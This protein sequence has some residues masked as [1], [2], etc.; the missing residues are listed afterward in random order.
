MQKGIVKW[1]SVEKGFGFIASEGKEYFIHFREIQSEGFKSVKPGD[2][3]C[4]E[5]SSSPKGLLATQVS[6][7]RG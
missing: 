4:F 2:K 3:V 6:L 7:S 1:F 5:P